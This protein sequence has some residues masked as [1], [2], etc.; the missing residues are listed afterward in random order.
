MGFTPAVMGLGFSLDISNTSLRRM[1]GLNLSTATNISIVGNSNLSAL[2]LGDLRTVKNLFVAGNGASASLNLSSLLSAW[3]IWIEGIVSTD[4]PVLE[5]VYIET[6]LQNNSFSDFN[7][8]ALPIM[9]SLSIVNNLKMSS[10]EFRS[11][12]PF[13]IFN[14][15]QLCITRYKWV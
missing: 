9:G 2:D 4:M 10:L 6:I 14:R 11:L 15:G 5:D 13:G 12:T 8:P 1:N 7:Y 3:A